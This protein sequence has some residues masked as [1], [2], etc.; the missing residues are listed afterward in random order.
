MVVRI[1]INLKNNM[2]AFFQQQNTSDTFKESSRVVSTEK[3]N[4]QVVYNKRKTSRTWILPGTISTVNELPD[5]NAFNWIIFEKNGTLTTKFIKVNESLCEIGSKH[6]YL[7]NSNMRIIGA[8]EMIIENKKCTFNLASG[9][10]MRPLF[11][12]LNYKELSIFK[13]WIKDFATAKWGINGKES[14]T[15]MV[16]IHAIYSGIVSGRPSNKCIAKLKN[17]IRYKNQIQYINLKPIHS[18]VQSVKNIFTSLTLDN[19]TLG[20]W[21]AL[22]NKGSRLLPKIINGT[23]IPSSEPDSAGAHGGVYSLLYATTQKNTPYM[24]KVMD[25]KNN[26]REKQTFLNEIRV[27]SIDGIHTVGPQYLAFKMEKNRGFIIMFAIENSITLEWFLTLGGIVDDSFYKKINKQLKNFYKI[28]QGYHGDLHGGNILIVPHKTVQKQ[29]V[30]KNGKTSLQ[31]HGPYPIGTAK[32][33]LII[34]YGGHRSFGVKLNT[35]VNQPLKNIMNHIS[36]EFTRNTSRINQYNPKQSNSAA[37][38]SGRGQLFQ[39]NSKYFKAWGPQWNY[40]YKKI[41]MHNK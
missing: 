8:G 30:Y 2:T 27:G 35:S 1:P 7:K 34:D 4:Y 28:T 40:M 11:S 25:F 5:N 15:E 12:L 6:F 22:N 9:T 23:I 18:T 24:I 26:L 21:V 3:Q 39:N 37:K 31:P 20:N 13:Q 17:N 36:K 38:N 32:Y 16:D 14:F 10:F 33:I 41:L 29:R 19:T